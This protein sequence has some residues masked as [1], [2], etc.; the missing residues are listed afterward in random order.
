[1]SA[2][3]TPGHRARIAVTQA[4]ADLLA[5]LEAVAGAHLAPNRTQVAELLRRRG[6]VAQ[7]A[8]GAWHSR[9]DGRDIRIIH[10]AT[11]VS[12][13]V[14]ATPAPTPAP[15]TARLILT[16]SQYRWLLSVTRAGRL[17]RTQ[18]ERRLA[19]RL[20]AAGLLHAIGDPPLYVPAAAARVRERRY[21]GDR[22][23]TIVIEHV[24][25][26]L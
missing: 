9:R 8:D 4:E 2:A 5:E 18:A 21:V 10:G 11:A 13:V 23:D 14:P 17:A 24:E 12:A 3:A 1:M 25:S 22:L 26:V 15:P 16:I 19:V 7:T 6:L 20:V